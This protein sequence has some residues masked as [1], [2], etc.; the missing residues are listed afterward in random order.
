MENYGANIAATPRI[1][2]TR[3]Q[4]ESRLQSGI[5]RLTSTPYVEERVVAN[6]DI[7]PTLYELAQIPIPEKVDGESFAGLLRNKNNE[8]W[9]EGILIEGLARQGHL[10]RLSHGRLCVRGNCRR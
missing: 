8:N 9:R 2:P 6:I 1:A 7:A 3:K 4:P 5:R 10:R